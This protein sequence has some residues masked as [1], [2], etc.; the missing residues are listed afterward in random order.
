MFLLG[1]LEGAGQ[2]S[3]HLLLLAKRMRDH[4]W[5][6]GAIWRDEDGSALKRD[7]Q[8]PRGFSARGLSVSEGIIGY[9][10]QECFWNTK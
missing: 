9:S 3:P 10:G 6:V 4:D 5:P 2:R 1:G 8:E 7:L